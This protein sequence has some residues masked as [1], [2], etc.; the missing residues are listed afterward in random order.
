MA[1]LRMMSLEQG[2][3]DVENI[4]SPHPRKYDAFEV[5]GQI[6]GEEERPTTQLQ[7]RYALDVASRLLELAKIG[8][9]VDVQLHMG[10]CTDPSVFN[11]FT[12]ALIVEDALIP[13]WAT[14]ELGALQPDEKSPVN[15][16]ADI[17]GAVM[18]EVLE[19]A[20]SERAGDV[21]TN[22]VI[23]VVFCDVISCGDCE[24]Y[25]PG[26]NKIFAVTLG[27]GGSPG[28][29]ADVVFSLDKGVAF[30]AHDVDSMVAADDPTGIACVGIYVVVI[31]N[32]TGGHHYA[33]KSEFNATDDP[34]FT[35]ITN[36]YVAGG[37]PNDISSLGPFAFIVGDGGYV[38]SLEDPTVGVTVLDAGVATINNLNAVNALSEDFAVAVGE[39]G[40]VIYT[41]S[42]SLWQAVSLRPVGVGIDLVSVL[43]HSE[44]YWL[45]GT[46][47]GRLFYTFDKGETWTEKAFAGSGTGVVRDITRSTDSVLW[48]SHDTTVPA[49]RIFRSYDGGNSW[50]QIPEGTAVI[51]AN[52]RVTALAACEWDPNLIVGVGLADDGADGFIVLGQD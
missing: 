10:Q 39:D 26:C 50:T 28:T 36:G 34:D 45:V 46:S 7:G 41:E 33:L 23:D 35:A 5:V 37:E 14:D 22:E 30:L 18:Y 4:Y 51:P 52:D 48:M 15:E 16:T 11:E 1:A 32:D 40:A 24:E 44:L 47:D 9:A 19:L 20:T 8:C 13:N 49:G 38:Y 29:P 27:A 2:F 12:K 21:V 25:S 17:S 3:G 42:G 6:R 31:S 43:V